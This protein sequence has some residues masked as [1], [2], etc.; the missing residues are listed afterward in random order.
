MRIIALPFLLLC[1]LARPARAVESELQ[2]FVLGVNGDRISVD[3][4]VVQ[5]LK[6]G[7]VGLLK[8]AGRRLA[9]VEVVTVDRTNAFL[10]VIDAAPGLVTVEG[11]TVFF[12]A[13][14]QEQKAKAGAGQGGEDEFVPLLAPPP[15]AQ[16]KAASKLTTHAH[17]RLRLWQFVQVVRPVD[18]RYRITRAES[19]GAV[20][21]IAGTAWSFV[22]SGNGSYR[23]GNHPSASDDFRKGR[24]H[25]QRLM[26]S[27]PLAGK[28]FVR[29]GRFFPN[30]LPG[31]GTVDGAAVQA[32]AA[33]ILIGAVAGARPDRRRQDPSSRELVGSLYASAEAG[34]PGKRSWGATAGVLHTLWDGRRDELAF[35]L[36]QRFDL[37]PMLGVYQSAQLDVD[38]GTAAV[39]KGARL[40]R[41]DLSMNSTPAERLTLRA[42]VSHF[43]P[44]DTAAERSVAAA[45]PALYIDNGYWRWWTGAGQSLPWGLGLDEEISWTSTGGRFL[46][47]LWR[48]T[49]SRTGLPGLPYGRTYA[50][51]YN[52]NNP[53]GADHG[54]SVGAT[55]PFLEGR[56]TADASAGFRYD[57]G[58][59]ASRRWRAGDAGLRLDWRPNPT[60]S[61][62][63]AATR[64]WQGAIHSTSLS[65]GVSYRW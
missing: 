58:D 4:G 39:H 48:A 13:P 10:R 18:A 31:L 47:G 64:V 38:A 41:F 19:D 61:A 30:E 17:G 15:L 36:D 14:G 33:G 63:L 16:K 37:G 28:G 44:V 7:D 8:R 51:V 3:L 46:P 50:T 62:D 12:A 40:T 42:G 22:W 24:A 52:L 23:D 27:H 32:P 59:G 26:L 49:L 54:G 21:R 65:G 60:W 35:L 45:D 6:P 2:G 1:L 56:L 43:E 57:R 25:F 5:G 11:D 55:A 9:S 20:E 29:L 53:A 34:E